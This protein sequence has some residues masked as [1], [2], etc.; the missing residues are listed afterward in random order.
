MM[1]ADF[2]TKL[3]EAL[4]RGTEGSGQGDLGTETPQLDDYVHVA[5]RLQV[6]VPAPIPRLADGRRR[7]LREAANLG[8]GEHWLDRWL[9]RVRA[10]PAFAL[11][12]AAVII[13]VIGGAL[14]LTTGSMLSGIAST[15]IWDSTTPTMRPT[16]TATPTQV[17]LLPPSSTA[18]R[19]NRAQSPKPRAL[20]APVSDAASFDTLQ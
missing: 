1:P 15:P 16:F 11:V 14:S 2:E 4:T 5:Q 17:S 8:A 13:L 19:P 20:P 18:V 9:G 10:R 3:D 7:F 12:M 6:L